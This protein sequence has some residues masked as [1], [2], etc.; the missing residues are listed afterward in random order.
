VGNPLAFFLL[1]SARDR[2]K[3]SQHDI[4]FGL[5]F[6]PTINRESMHYEF[7]VFGVL[8]YVFPHRR[9]NDVH[10]QSALSGPA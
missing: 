8:R 3:R 10:H 7:R 6:I 2:T 9:T 5:R 1:K 4:E